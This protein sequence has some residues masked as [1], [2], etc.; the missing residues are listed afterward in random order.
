MNKYKKGDILISL[1]PYKERDK[2]GGEAFI[3]AIEILKVYKKPVRDDQ[4]LAYHL[5]ENF[6]TSTNDEYL[7]RNKMFITDIPMYPKIGSGIRHYLVDDLG[8]IIKKH[9]YKPSQRQFK[10]EK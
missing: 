4:Y 6:L 5:T 1:T 2:S 3:N 8:R 9:F 10:K 7:E